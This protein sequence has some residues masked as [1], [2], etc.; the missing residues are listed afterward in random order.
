M[1]SWEFPG[2]EPIDILIDITAGSVA[3]SAEPTDV[4]TVLLEASGRGGERLAAELSVGFD[5]GRLQIIEPKNVRSLFRGFA[6]LDV[7]VTAPAGSSCEVRTASADVS[8]MGRLAELEARTASGDV[9]AGSVTG[10]LAVRTASGDVWLER[11]GATAQVNTASG[12]VQLRQADGDV[13]VQT[14]SGDVAIGQAAASVHVQTASGDTRV[15]SAAAGEVST[16]TASGDTQ[17]GVAAGVG[18]Y[19]DLSSLTG[20]IRTELDET[21]GSDDVGLQVSC[22]SVTGGIRIT[23]A[24]PVPAA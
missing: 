13:S 10:P 21:D 3:V 19:L 8:C 1:S 18:V 23:R 16:K 2:S 24:E 12:D 4:T 5:Q 14:A 11:A 7:T 9:T 22:R 15:G 6:G 17:V 20:N